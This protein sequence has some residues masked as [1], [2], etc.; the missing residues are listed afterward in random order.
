L[1]KVI[2]IEEVPMYHVLLSRHDH[3][4]Y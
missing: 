1:N 4:M 3:R 2:N